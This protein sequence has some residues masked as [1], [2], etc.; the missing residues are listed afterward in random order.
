MKEFTYA[1]EFEINIKCSD[2]LSGRKALEAVSDKIQRDGV[3]DGIHETTTEG[4]KVIRYEIK[5]IPLYKG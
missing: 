4:A 2:S 1:R 3:E 5:S